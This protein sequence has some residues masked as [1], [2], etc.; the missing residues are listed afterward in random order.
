MVEFLFDGIGLQQHYAYTRT[1]SCT[2][3]SVLNINVFDNT[4]N[5]LHFLSSFT[6]DPQPFCTT[7]RRV[8]SVGISDD[9]SVGVVQLLDHWPSSCYSA[10]PNREDRLPERVVRGWLSPHELLPAPDSAASLSLVW[11]GLG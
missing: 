11:G 10:G 8:T 9:S 6:C 2:S 7:L 4:P 1:E 5:R 3:N